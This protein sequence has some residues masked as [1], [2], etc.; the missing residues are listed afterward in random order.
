MYSS[1]PPA[2][3]L[4][5]Q[6]YVL[7][8]KP[9]I[10]GS[11]LACTPPRFAGWLAGRA[12]SGAVQCRREGQSRHCGAA[13]NHLAL[14]PR[15]EPPPPPRHSSRRPAHPPPA[16]GVPI[17]NPPGPPRSSSRR[18][19]TPPQTLGPS[20]RHPTC[21]TPDGTTCPSAVLPYFR[22]T[23]TA[24]LTLLYHCYSNQSTLC[25]SSEGAT[26]SLAVIRHCWSAWRR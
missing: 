5:A 15:P 4:R 12:L 17:W 14:L 8:Q 20:T 18:W 25:Q 13:T 1:S 16:S 9:L 23:S 22:T 26:I 3:V 11:L 24:P 19:R 2:P 21:H 6:V 7:R 10:M